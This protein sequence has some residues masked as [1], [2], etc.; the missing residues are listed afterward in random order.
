MIL[1]N[2]YQVSVEGYMEHLEL[3]ETE[4]V[5]L[6]KKTVRLA[7]TAKEKFL[8]ETYQAGLSVEEGW[9]I[10]PMEFLV[11]LISLFIFIFICL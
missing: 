7:H 8:K 3:N 10:I 5:E 2:T 9:H 6:I 11:F 1:T 4:S